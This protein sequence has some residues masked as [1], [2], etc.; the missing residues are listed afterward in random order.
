MI[1]PQLSAPAAAPAA[2]PRRHRLVLA[3]WVGR[4]VLALA[5]AAARGELGEDAKP[6]GE[7][8]LAAFDEEA[9]RREGRAAARGQ[10]RLLD[11]GQRTYPTVPELRR[12]RRAPDGAA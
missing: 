5:A 9:E 12:R 10:L 6:H 2:P 1:A 8:V 7:P 11:L 4:V 3:G